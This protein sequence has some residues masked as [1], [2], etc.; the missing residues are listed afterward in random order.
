MTAG[1]LVLVV[2]FYTAS[3]F[4]QMA[5]STAT[6][7]PPYDVSTVKGYR[8]WAFRYAAAMCD[9]PYTDIWAEPA[10]G[11]P[12]VT[13]TSQVKFGWVRGGGIHHLGI[14]A[15]EY[16]LT[17]GCNPARALRG[18][19][20]LSRQPLYRGAIRARYVLCTTPLA[21]YQRQHS[22]WRQSR[23]RPSSYA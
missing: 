6:S 12:A 14:S 23:R 18:R 10:G 19:P 8:E 2:V 17:A 7:T 3:A 20:A 4:G 13:D 22:P 9:N 1:I 15:G 5:T 16:G 11:F 21:A